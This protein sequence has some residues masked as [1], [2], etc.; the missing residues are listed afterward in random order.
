MEELKVKFRENME[1]KHEDLMKMAVDIFQ[2]SKTSL[3]ELKKQPWYKKFLNS[4]IFQKGNRKY[5]LKNFTNLTDLIIVFLKVYVQELKDQNTALNNI[6]EN[7][8]KTQEAVKK[9]YN[10]CVLKFTDLGNIVELKNDVDASKY[11]VSFLTMFNNDL[12]L[13]EESYNSLKAY[14]LAIKNYLGVLVVNKIEDVSTI[15]FINNKYHDVFYRCALEQCVVTNSYDKENE[16]F[17]FPESVLAALNYL[18]VSRNKTQELQNLVRNELENFG[19]QSFIDKYS[20]SNEWIDQ[21]ELDLVEEQENNIDSGEDDVKESGSYSF[22]AFDG[23]KALI[24]KAVDSEALGKKIEKNDK[25]QWMLSRL[26]FLTPKTVISITKGDKV[27]LLFTTYALY[28][29]TAGGILKDEL[30]WSLPYEIISDTNI[31]TELNSKEPDRFI[32]EDGTVQKTFSDN[33]IS[34]QKLEQLLS[35]IK[36][37]GAF[38]KTD[39]KLNFAELN[40]DIKVGY[41]HI[42]SAILKENK[43]P[44]FELFRTVSDEGLDSYWDRI[45]QEENDISHFVLQWQ[46][47]IPYPY[48]EAVALRLLGSICTILQYTKQNETLNANEKKYFSLILK[49]LEASERD[50]AIK[51]QILCSQVEKKFIEGKQVEGEL[52]ELMGFVKDNKYGLLAIT[53][54]SL[55][56]IGL[57]VLGPL[58]WIAKITSFMGLSIFDYISKRKVREA[59]KAELR[60]KLY[61]EINLS[62]KRALKACETVVNSDMTIMQ[63]LKDGIDVLQKKSGFANSVLLSTHNDEIVEAV[64][65]FLNDLESKYKGSSLGEVVI[66][67]KLNYFSFQNLIEQMSLSLGKEDKESVLGLHDGKVNSGSFIGNNYSGVLFVKEGCYIKPDADAPIKFIFYSEI[68]EVEVKGKILQEVVLYLFDGT[69]IK[70]NGYN[71]KEDGSDVLFKRIALWN[72]EDYIESNRTDKDFGESAVMTVSSPLKWL[73]WL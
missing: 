10:R 46:E 14:N 64:K 37:L 45:I 35:D 57:T 69:T 33:N 50:E 60:E 13:D 7:V 54:G 36:R 6:V 71:Y 15:E 49:A 58:G 12:G 68:V 20:I 25:K 22:D 26:S 34:V 17:D 47:E 38:A 23:L 24:S 32:F 59:N 40:L 52:E 48:E 5:E 9:I 11:L 53:G 21:D 2:E 65:V 16:C 4:L 28:V 27:Y 62:Y 70:L 43:Q 41:Y 8:I 1:I 67:S 72:R 19:K 73:P 30:F 42:I 39:K 55:I 3:E 29:Y 31:G 61:K 51:N 18:N 56:S 63:N 66:A 44:L